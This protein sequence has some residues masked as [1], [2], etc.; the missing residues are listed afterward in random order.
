[1]KHLKKFNE[2]IF[3]D[4]NF[5]DIDVDPL[6][7]ELKPFL[8]DLKDEYSYLEGFIHKHSDNEYEIRLDV[9]HLTTIEN[10]Y[11]LDSLEEKSKFISDVLK[12]CRHIESV[13]K[14]EFQIRVL[15]LFTYTRDQNSIR[16]FLNSI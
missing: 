13:Y 10:T 7:M 14:N 12:V 11:T 6:L 15:N 8:I 3:K 9:S 16:I 1:M 2:N 4:Y 5:S